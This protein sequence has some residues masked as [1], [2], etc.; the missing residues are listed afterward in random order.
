MAANK[1]LKK[2]R[3]HI[4]QWTW[5]H[6][7]RL[8]Q[9][10]ALIAFVVFFLQSRPEG[11]PGDWVNIPMRLDPLV[12][13]ANL[14]SSKVFLAGSSLAI[15]TLLLTLTAGRAWCGWLCP[16]GTVLDIFTPARK[17][18]AVEP[19]EKWRGVKYGL[20]ITT[21]TAA[22]FGNLTLLVLDPLAILFRSLT[23]AVW[24]ALDHIITSSQAALFQIPALSDPISSLDAW[25]RPYI[26][27][28]TPIYN[29]DAWVFLVSIRR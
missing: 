7:R 8:V 16:L 12:V 24:P 29:R 15:L 5:V 11:W 25:L 20:L 28:P 22:L 23:T 1:T 3:R 13:L 18:D 4:S 26:L 6:S 2:S 17:K 10:L 9:G 19:D 27:P 21:L 14:L